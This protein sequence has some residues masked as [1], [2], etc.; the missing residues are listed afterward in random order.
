M[1]SMFGFPESATTLFRLGERVVSVLLVR[2]A[3]LLNRFFGHATVGVSS[4]KFP[5]FYLLGA[6]GRIC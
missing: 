4:Q 3:H 6:F 1:I 5:A 2:N